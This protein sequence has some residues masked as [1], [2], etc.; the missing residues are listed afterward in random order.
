VKIS[1][2]KELPPMRESH[3]VSQVLFAY[4]VST[5]FYQKTEN[6]SKRLGKLNQFLYTYTDQR[7]KTVMTFC[8]LGSYFEGIAIIFVFWKLISYNYYSRVIFCFQLKYIHHNN[9]FTVSCRMCICSGTYRRV[10]FKFNA[11]WK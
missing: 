9:F 11:L 8:E 7:P 10:I 1:F 4:H 6:R 5:M 3:Y 2:I